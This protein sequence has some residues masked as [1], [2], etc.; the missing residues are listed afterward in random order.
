MKPF[1][2]LAAIILWPVNIVLRDLRGAIAIL[3]LCLG[4]G[5][6]DLIRISPQLFDLDPVIE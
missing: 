1:N 3:L 6:A 4:D 2:F 5:A